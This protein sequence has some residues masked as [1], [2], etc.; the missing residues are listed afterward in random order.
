[1]KDN[2]CTFHWPKRV[3]GHIIKFPPPMSEFCCFVGLSKPGNF[4]TFFTGVGDWSE[5]LNVSLFS[6]KG[7]LVIWLP[8]EPPL[9][10]WARRRDMVMI[11][12]PS[13]I[14]SAKIFNWNRK[15]NH[16]NTFKYKIYGK[17]EHQSELGTYP[18]SGHLKGTRKLYRSITRK[19]IQVHNKLPP[20]NTHTPLQGE[21]V[22]KSNNIR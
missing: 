4:T 19:C 22:Y 8:N 16:S 10:E 15:S 14:A 11:V 7:W 21:P 5:T 1:M 9:S 3:I 6:L 17:W 2:E 13:P 12:F 18:S 20:E